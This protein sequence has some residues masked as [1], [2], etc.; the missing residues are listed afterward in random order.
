MN[1]STNQLSHLILNVNKNTPEQPILSFCT[2]AKKECA[3]VGFTYLRYDNLIPGDEISKLKDALETL[4][5]STFSTFVITD[6][7]Q[8]LMYLD[9]AGI[10]SAA[11]YNDDN[12]N[13]DML[14]ALYCIEDIGYMTF[15][16]IRKM[17]ERSCGI[18]W[19]IA[20][21]DRLI[22]REQTPEDLDELYDLYDDDMIRQFVEPLYEDRIREEEY[23][24]EYIANQYRFYEYGIWALVRKRDGRLI[25]RA[26]ISLREGYDTPEIGYV[27]GSSYRRCGY[28]KEAL[29]AIIEYAWSELGTDRLISFTK[30]RNKASVKLLKT[31]GFERR[32]H[33]DVMGSDHTMYVLTKQ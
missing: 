12:R 29:G 31:L 2:N 25:G 18:P 21:T 6:S 26:G 19:T 17:W 27:I 33:A 23:L 5:N 22:I 14:P 13:T 7:R 24:R 32:G 11:L 20:V 28:A 10:A 3:S 16:R 15:D 30:E 9:S 1:E 4:Q 8:A